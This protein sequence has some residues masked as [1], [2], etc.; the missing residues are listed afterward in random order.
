MATND[1]LGEHTPLIGSIL[2]ECTSQQQATTPSPDKSGQSV[3]LTMSHSHSLHLCL[4]TMP[5]TPTQ[6][7]SPS[8]SAFCSLFI[9]PQRRTNRRSHCRTVQ[10]SSSGAHSNHKDPELAGGESDRSAPNVVL[11]HDVDVIDIDLAERHNVAPLGSSAKLWHHPRFKWLLLSIGL[12]FTFV[13]GVNVGILA[14][15]RGSN[16]IEDNV[17]NKP[18]PTEFDSRT[19]GVWKQGQSVSSCIRQGS[20]GI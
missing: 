4:A 1:K 15:A 6:T 5:T 8:Q 19:V 7:S 13:I 2:L 11:D 18:H 17:S 16:G 14:C 12:L 9:K 3:T 10:P 20:Q